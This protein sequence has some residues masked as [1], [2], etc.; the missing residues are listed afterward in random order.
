MA[1]ERTSRTRC[2]S[3]LHGS[4]HTDCDKHLQNGSVKIFRPKENAA[5]LRMSAER[6]VMAPFPEELF[7]EAVKT[8]VRDNIDYVP[9]YG[10]GGS[11]Y[12]RPLLFGSGPR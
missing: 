2:C 11:L 7:V 9:P 5:R 10:T 3:L 12:I 8:L 6:L 4:K 1:G